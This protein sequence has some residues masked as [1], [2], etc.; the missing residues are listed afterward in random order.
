MIFRIVNI[1]FFDQLKDILK[2]PNDQLAP[3]PG[4]QAGLAAKVEQKTCTILV[5]LVQF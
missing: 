3:Q 1:P 2:I 5:K 4:A